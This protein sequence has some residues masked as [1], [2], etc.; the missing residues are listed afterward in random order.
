MAGGHGRRIG[1]I[2]PPRIPKAERRGDAGDLHERERQRRQKLTEQL[3]NI[4]A[5]LSKADAR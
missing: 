3:K 4:R 1:K 5:A 2:V